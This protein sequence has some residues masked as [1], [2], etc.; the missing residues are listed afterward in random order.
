MNYKRIFLIVMDSVGIGAAKDSDKFG[1][2][3]SNTLGHIIEKT[4]LKLPNLQM[5][6]LYNIL[7]LEETKTIGYY[8]KALPASNGKDSLT[9][10]LEMMGIKTKSA[11]KTFTE[12]GFPKDLI[13]AI[14]YETERKVIG[15]YS[16]SGEEIIEKLGEEHMKTGSIIIYTSADSVLQVAAHESIIPVKE[17]YKICEIIRKVTLKDEWKVGRVIARPFKGTPG[18]FIRL[19][20][21]RKDFSIDP[22]N[23]TV[24]DILTENKYNV[25]SIGKI[26]DLFNNKGITA[27]TRVNDNLEAIKKIVKTMKLNFT[28]LCFANL[29]DF[30]SKYGHRRD[31]EG[32]ANCLQEFDKYLPNIVNSLRPDDLL[33][34]TADHGNDPTYVGTDHTRENTP[35]LIFSRKFKQNGEIPYLQSFADIGA[36]IAENFGCEAPK[37]GKSFL[38]K[39]K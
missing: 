30:D 39:L 1:D 14:E 13:K 31:V 6:G 28:G 15:N 33:I 2:G 17:L 19:N 4:N 7:D 9:G 36:T 35:V 25:L 10:H 29:N 37:Q 24:L 32:Y 26:A 22:A 20:D 21:Q 16:S 23:K 3:T 27:T 34:I 12:K 8:T 38:N 18:N 5:M 11:P